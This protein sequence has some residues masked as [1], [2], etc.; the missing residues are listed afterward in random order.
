MDS[1][2]EEN[3]DD[4]LPSSDIDMFTIKEKYGHYMRI[5]LFADSKQKD[6]LISHLLICLKSLLLLCTM[7]GVDDALTCV[8]FLFMFLKKKSL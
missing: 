3:V 8:S 4:I 7:P 5:K 2:E 1:I 6:D